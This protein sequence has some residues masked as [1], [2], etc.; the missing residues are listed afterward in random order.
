MECYEEGILNLE[1]TGGLDLHFGQA[2][3]APWR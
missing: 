1:R 3:N 2:E